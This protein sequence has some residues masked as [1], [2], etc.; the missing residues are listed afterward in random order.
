MMLRVSY[1][2]PRTPRLGPGLVPSILY[3]PGAEA[4]QLPLKTRKQHVTR[5]SF[6]LLPSLEDLLCTEGGGPGS[7]GNESSKVRLLEVI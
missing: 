3:R 5:E 7:R 4:A 1:R 2:L 6:I